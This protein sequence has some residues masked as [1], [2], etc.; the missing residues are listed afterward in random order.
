M[1]IVWKAVEQDDRKCGGIAALV[2]TDLQDVR[3]NR[4][5]CGRRGRLRCETF[6][7]GRGK[8]GRRA[9]DEESAM[10]GHASLGGL[11]AL[12]VPGA[13]GTVE[14]EDHVALTAA[15]LL[16]IPRP[17]LPEAPGAVALR[18]NAVRASLA[19]VRQRLANRLAPNGEE[20]G[21][22]GPRLGNARE[23]CGVIRIAR[24]FV[25]RHGRI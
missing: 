12:P 13:I 15:G 18:R 19:L 2:V 24:P 25:T 17:T 7:G 9:L 21:R 22:P 14:D 16:R 23:I 5:Q 20:P 3:T 8:D 1:R 4:L 6:K 11:V 10:H